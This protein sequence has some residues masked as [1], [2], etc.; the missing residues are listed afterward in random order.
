MTIDWNKI[1]GDEFKT[2]RKIVDRASD[3]LTEQ[4]VKHDKLSLLM[5]VQA[6][7]LACP[8]RLADMLT[9]NESDLMHDISGIV[10]HLNRETGELMDCFVPRHAAM[11]IEVTCPW[12]NGS[13][14]MKIKSTFEGKTTASTM[15]CCHCEGRGEWEKHELEAYQAQ[16]KAFWCDCENPH[17]DHVE[18]YEEED[19][20]HGWKCTDC[21]KVRQTG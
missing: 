13:G 6:A 16:L 21:G 5:D 3:L 10:R 7:H 9:A 1:G 18:Y 8:L 4:D 20:R 2:I 14:E 12:C 17:E 11:I 19:G 15:T